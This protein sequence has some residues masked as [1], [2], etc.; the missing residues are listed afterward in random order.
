MF[1]DKNDPGYMV[2]IKQT[3]SWGNYFAAIM[4]TTDGGQSWFEVTS[5]IDTRIGPLSVWVSRN[6]P[7]TMVAVQGISY[8]GDVIRGHYVY[9]SL[10]GG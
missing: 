6:F 3:G 1:V 9:T 5:G 4:K 10:T 7:A 2:A 8:G